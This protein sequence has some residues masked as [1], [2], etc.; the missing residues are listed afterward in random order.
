MAAASGSLAFLGA[1]RF[2][3][4]W[5]A[6][7][8]WGTGSNHPEGS[9]SGGVT[10]SF[11]SLFTSGD[12]VDGGYNKAGSPAGVSITASLGDYW[13]VIVDGSTNVDG[14]ASWRANDWIIYSG[15]TG[16]TAGKKWTKLAFDDTIASIVIGDLSG[17]DLFHLT[18]SADKHVLFIAGTE[19]SSVVMS[20]SSGFTYD[21]TT[22]VLAL[23]GSSK[24]GIGTASPSSVLHTQL[25]GAGSLPSIDNDTIA[26]FQRNLP[27]Y[28]SAAITILGH[29]AGESIIKFGDADD[30]D[31][32][33]I[34]YQHTNNSMDFFTNNSE[35][36]TID[37]A[38]KVGIG[39][40]TPVASALLELSSTTQGFLPPS[41]TTT[42]RNAIG[43]P[44]EGLVVYNETTNQ[45]NVYD[46]SS[47]TIAGGAVVNGATENELVTVASTVTELDAE[48]N[49]TFDGS[50]NTLKVLG[51]VTANV[52]SNIATIAVNTTLTAGYN[53]LMLGPITLNDGITLTVQDGAALKIK[54][55]SDI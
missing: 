29:A 36:M 39:T 55:I 43:S 15:S 21:Y 32:G 18:G 34:R 23:T 37:S 5:D 12:S 16:T 51:A 19:D 25:D 13:Q 14:F 46:G 52:I 10:G 24:L 33:R 2:Q 30:E 47:W 4:F 42:E 26:L 27:G 1:A 9:V 49:L 41:L 3:G 7:N 6:A 53:S 35:A 48:A 50:T 22:S 40:A 45:L 38:G 31:I 28:S 54:D 20:G 8:N 11:T 44:A 17:T